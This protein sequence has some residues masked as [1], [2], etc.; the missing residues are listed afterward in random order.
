MKVF[1]DVVQQ[2]WN[3]HEG[4]AVLA[5]VGADGWPNVDYVSGVREFGDDTLA[6]ADNYLNKTRANIQAG[7][8]GALVFITAERKSYQV[9]GS[10][11]YH[12]SGPIFDDM[13]K[14][15]PAKHPGVAAVAL[16]V[17]QIYCGAERLV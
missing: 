16:K 3:N 12:T 10:F 8:R 7:S 11:T 4:P 15:N 6:I 14:W 13:K 5:T 17:E 1:P 9:K 2:A